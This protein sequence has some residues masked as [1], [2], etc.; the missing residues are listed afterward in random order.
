MQR[1]GRISDAR[2]HLSRLCPPS[3]QDYASDPP[4]PKK[5]TPLG[6]SHQPT[7]SLQQTRLTCLFPFPYRAWYPAES[8]LRS[9]SAK[10]PCPLRP[11]RCLSIFCS[12]RFLSFPPRARPFIL[13]RNAMN[14]SS[15][16][17]KESSGSAV[18][19]GPCRAAKKEPRRAPDAGGHGWHC[20]AASF[21][22]LA[23]PTSLSF[24]CDLSI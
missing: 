19:K 22:A 17:M 8:A 16:Q 24:P 13:S 7:L 14:W 21:V 1:R 3:R 15:K 9:G 20:I 18:C 2:R 4:F 23:V 6:M 11:A 10:H 12:F 5:R